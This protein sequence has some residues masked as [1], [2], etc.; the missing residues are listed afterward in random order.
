[1]KCVI[2]K[3]T[4]SRKWKGEKVTIISWANFLPWLCVCVLNISSLNNEMN[5][6][7]PEGTEGRT[8]D[9]DHSCYWR[10]VSDPPC[11]LCSALG[12]YHTVIITVDSAH[13][14]S[15][16]GN[17]YVITRGIGNLQI[18][19]LGPHRT[20]GLDRTRRGRF[21]SLLANIGSLH[22]TGRHRQ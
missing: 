12:C 20:P 13:H 4:Q 1:M 17:C 2:L 10:I 8:E 5:K 7:S 16:G 19:Q 11:L 15:C 18:H 9:T 21:H 6:S 3:S 14:L 22:L